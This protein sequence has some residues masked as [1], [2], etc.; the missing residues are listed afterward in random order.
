MSHLTRLDFAAAAVGV[1]TAVVF[2]PLFFEGFS[3]LVENLTEWGGSKILSIGQCKVIFYLI[4]VGG[5]AYSA[6]WNF[7]RWFPH[8]FK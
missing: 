4:I 5:A 6:H 2:F 7:P 8:V 3:G 1:L